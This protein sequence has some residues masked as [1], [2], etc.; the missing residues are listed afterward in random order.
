MRPRP[1][2][3]GFRLC[4]RTRFGESLA[5][6]SW[7]S[8]RPGR[9]SIR[10]SSSPESPWGRKLGYA[11]TLEEV[12]DG[13]IAI[14]VRIYD[15]GRADRAVATV[16]VAGPTARLSTEALTGFPPEIR[17]TAHRLGG[18]WATYVHLAPPG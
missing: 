18:E 3:P 6:A 7:H 17:K 8:G 10:R 4:R 14:A 15:R 11:I 9:R 2:R 16:S 5:R 13:I 12:E 1:A